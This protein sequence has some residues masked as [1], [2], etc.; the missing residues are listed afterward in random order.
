[1]HGHDAAVAKLRQ[2]AKETTNEVRVMHVPTKS[3]VAALNDSR[4]S[5]S[6]NGDKSEMRAD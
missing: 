1:V 4:S 2:L 5:F 6:S 3:V